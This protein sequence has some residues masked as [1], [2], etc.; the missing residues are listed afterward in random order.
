MNEMDYLEEAK[1]QVDFVEAQ[2]SEEAYLKYGRI[3]TQMAI[4][5]T[6]IALVELLKSAAEE[7][8]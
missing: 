6:F 2:T 4:A 8:S 1:K 3:G 7:N 5:Y